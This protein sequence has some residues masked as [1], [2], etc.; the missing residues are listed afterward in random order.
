MPAQVE[1]SAVSGIVTN[2]EQ[3]RAQLEVQGQS[4][5][6]D[7]RLLREEVADKQQ[8][9]V[10]LQCVVAELEEE[11]ASR[12]HQHQQDIQEYQQVSAVTK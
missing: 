12:T 6:V 3:E 8:Q 5:L 9:L 7:N 4:A 11:R 1:L 10:Q 2:L